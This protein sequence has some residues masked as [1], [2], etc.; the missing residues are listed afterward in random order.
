MTV[1]MTFHF[2]MTAHMSAP[3]FYSF[4]DSWQTI[5]GNPAQQHTFQPVHADTI[6]EVDMPVD[7][8]T[9]KYL[10]YDSEPTGI[11]QPLL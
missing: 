1:F 11:H 3:L 10:A 7:G 2:P 9:W 6:L 8:N 5:A 4:S